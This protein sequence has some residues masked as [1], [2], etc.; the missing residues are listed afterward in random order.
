MKDLLWHEP[1]KY[2]RAK[3]NQMEKANPL[4]SLQFAGV[5]FAIILA[6][7]G[8]AGM[9]P[10]PGRHPPDWGITA[11]IALGAA[12]FAAYLLPRFVGLFANSIV[13]LSS[14]GVNNNSVHGGATV[15]FW[16][17]S[18]IAFCYAW[19]ERLNGIDYKVL[20]FCD[21]ASVVHTTL[22]LDKPERMREVET[23]LRA[24][25]IPLQHETR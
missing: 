5:A 13:I 6:L 22:C 11:L 7:R 16:P 15:R 17:W 2:R 19:T 18:K 8:L 14:K 23:M 3:Y 4:K 25:N 12:V 9:S 1:A 20:S 24:N 21:A 10:R